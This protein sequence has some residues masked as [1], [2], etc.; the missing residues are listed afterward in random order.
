MTRIQFE[1]AAPNKVRRKVLLMLAVA[2]CLL[3]CGSSTENKDPSPE[4]Q[5]GLLSRWNAVAVGVTVP[6]FGDF[7]WPAFDQFPHPTFKGGSAEAYGLFA[8]VLVAFFQREDNFDFLEKNRLFRVSLRDVFPSGQVGIETTFEKL[9]A[10]L[11]SNTWA[12]ISDD[13]RQKLQ[14][15]DTRIRAE[16]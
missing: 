8:D 6:G 12:S 3:A 4:V 7:R 5:A 11:S 10:E 13:T 2:A 15:F 14:A 9:T 1:W 16:P